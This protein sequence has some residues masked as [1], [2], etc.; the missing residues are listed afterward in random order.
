LKFQIALGRKDYKRAE[1]IL[2]QL[3]PTDPIAQQ[4]II[5]ARVN[6]LLA[7]DTSEELPGQ[8]KK[9]KIL[10]LLKEAVKTHDQSAYLV[11]LLAHFLLQA[12]DRDAVEQVL[13]DG[14]SRMESPQ[15]RLELGLLL[16]GLLKQ[17]E[18]DDLSETL[19]KKLDKKYPGTILVQ[20]HLLQCN[21]GGQLA[22]L[23]RSRQ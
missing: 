10:E 18:Q 5:V 9:D 3:A 11:R 1:E 4:Q 19:L 22:W 7:Q 23:W 20:R 15:S 8:D 17:W 16:S 12:G 13:A 14:M 6:L 21:F 2:D